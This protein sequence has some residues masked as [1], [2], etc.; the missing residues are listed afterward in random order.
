MRWSVA[1][2]IHKIE[3]EV[4]SKSFPIYILQNYT[5]KSG[6]DS[7]KFLLPLRTANPS[8]Q[9]TYNKSRWIISLAV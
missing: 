3:E 5:D 8:Q 9:A 6:S 4:P 1:L 7:T 2:E